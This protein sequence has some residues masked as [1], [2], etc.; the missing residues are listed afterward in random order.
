MKVWELEE[1]KKYVSI[2]DEDDTII[3]TVDN[4][5]NLYYNDLLCESEAKLFSSVRY[6]DIIK[7]DFVEYVD[8]DW[9]KVEVDTKILVKCCS[10]QENWDKRHFAK[11]ENG[12]IYVW[13]DGLTSFTV[14]DKNDYTEWEFSELYEE[15]K[16]GGDI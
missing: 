11:Y 14:N 1:G 9:A 15:E 3:Y 6:N 4:H 5:G 2:L 8:V 12:K 13:R 16:I 7:C 10:S